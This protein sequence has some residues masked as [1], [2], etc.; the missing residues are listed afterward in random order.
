MARQLRHALNQR[1]TAKGLHVVRC[2]WQPLG[3][4]GVA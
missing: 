3:G 1:F 4:N 2:Q